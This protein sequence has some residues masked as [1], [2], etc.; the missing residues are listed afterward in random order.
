MLEK[1]WR[2]KYERWTGVIRAVTA[3]EKGCRHQATA[4][5]DWFWDRLGGPDAVHDIQFALQKDERGCCQKIPKHSLSEIVG[6]IILY[7]HNSVA[8][9]TL[10]SDTVA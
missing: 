7:L 3:Q 2:V 5:N 8:A 6:N 1:F 10:Y 9:N 4:H